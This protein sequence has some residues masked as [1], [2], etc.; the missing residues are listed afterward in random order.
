MTDKHIE[1]VP[2]P[3]NYLFEAIRC[4]EREGNVG[5][6]WLW[7]HILSPGRRKE[8]DAWLVADKHP[9]AYQAGSAESRFRRVIKEMAD[10]F[11]RMDDAN[12]AAQGW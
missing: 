10:E 9:L 2:E 5:L 8:F 6:D 4:F 7:F 3:P 11:Q 12:K 1:Q